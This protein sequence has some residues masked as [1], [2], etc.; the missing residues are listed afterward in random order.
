MIVHI[1]KKPR[2]FISAS[3]RTN[4]SLAAASVPINHRQA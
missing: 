3:L 2:K 1:V 4:S